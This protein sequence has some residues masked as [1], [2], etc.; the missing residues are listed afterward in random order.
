MSKTGSF[1]KVLAAAAL[2]LAV[3][4]LP[5][6]FCPQ[7]GTVELVSYEQDVPGPDDPADRLG[8][9]MLRSRDVSSGSSSGGE[10]AAEPDYSQSVIDEF[11]AFARNILSKGAGGSGSVEGGPFS[12]SPEYWG[13]IYYAHALAAASGAVDA[14]AGQTTDATEDPSRQLNN[15]ST[16]SGSTVEPQYASPAPDPILSPA[17]SE[18]ITSTQPDVEISPGPGRSQPSSGSDAAD[19]KAPKPNGSSGK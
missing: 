14:S 11:L 4:G 8:L 15:P 6:A 5:Q 2:P 17:A 13:E 19:P 10:S 16:A 7:S 1:G 3:G 12:D 18:P 9:W